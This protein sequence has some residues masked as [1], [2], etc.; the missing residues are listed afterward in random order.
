MHRTLS[1]L[2]TC[3]LAVSA[4]C[5]TWSHQYYLAAADYVLASRENGNHE[6]ETYHLKVRGTAALRVEKA[7]L[8]ER[9]FLGLKLIELDEVMAARRGVPPGS[10][11]LITGVYPQSAAEIAGVL[12][13]DVLLTIDGKDITQLSQAAVAE[14]ELRVG[15]PV[16]VRLRRDVQLLDLELEAKLLRERVV[17]SQDVPL[18]AVAPSPR[19][20]AGTSLQGIPAVWCERMFGEVRNAVVV[21]DIEVGSPAWVAGVRAG[22]VIDSVDGQP[23]PSALELSQRIA[24]LGA[25][26]RTMLW[27]LRRGPGQFHDA[28]IHLGDYSGERNAWIPLVLYYQ[29]GSYE[30]RWTVGPFGL[31]LSNRNTYLTDTSGRRPQTR[32]VFSAVLGLLRVETTPHDTEVRLLW[33][34]R[35][36]C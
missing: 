19:P 24:E 31:L 16:A 6:R 25:D 23:V 18:E 22:D 11:L 2:L 32:N 14:G 15:Q 3:G 1:L 9:P 36:P 29:N 10:G 33:F 26:G 30:D 13:G 4:S 12:A 35:F 34:I 8:R 5:R 20:F 28:E 27:R 21:S 7:G 17:E